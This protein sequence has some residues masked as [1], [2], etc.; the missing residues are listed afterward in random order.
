MIHGEPARARIFPAVEA[1]GWGQAVRL[2]NPQLIG[3]LFAGA[4]FLLI[5]AVLCVS[6]L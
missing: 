2:T 6:E 1:Q 3:L 4:G 5:L